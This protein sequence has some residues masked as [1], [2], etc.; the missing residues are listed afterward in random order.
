MRFNVRL[1]L[2]GL[3]LCAGAVTAWSVE[4]SS[5]LPHGSREL[6]HLM[7]AKLASSQ[8]VVEG[9]VLRDF[10]L[11]RRGGQE[12]RQ[13]CEATQWRAQED[14]MYAH[15]RAEMRRQA[16]KLVLQAEEKNLDGAAYSYMHALTTCINCH[17]HC[18]DVLH[19]ASLRPPSRVIPI[20]TTDE[21]AITPRRNVR[22]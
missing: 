1:W 4:P 18:R 12:L 11:I 10:G 6:P 16:N 22:R 13:I 8:R 19:I 14:Q 17:D 9:L 15:Y 2:S 21:E 7:Q 5:P 3:A 20:P